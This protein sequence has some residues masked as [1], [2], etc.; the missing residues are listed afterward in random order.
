MFIKKP[1][2]GVIVDVF[3]YF[4]QVVFAPNYVFKIVSLPNMFFKRGK[5]TAFDKFYI[6]ICCLCFVPLNYPV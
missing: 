4:I 6:F 5:D 3:A 2:C 1:F